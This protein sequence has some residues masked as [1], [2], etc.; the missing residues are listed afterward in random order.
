MESLGIEMQYTDLS[1]S[2]PAEDESE[3]EISRLKVELAEMKQ[4]KSEFHDLLQQLR[5]IDHKMAL[6]EEDD[7][8]KQRENDQEKMILNQKCEEI[9]TLNSMLE[10]ELADIRAKF[11]KQSE[12]LHGEQ[13][14]KLKL[15]SEVTN[16]KAQLKIQQQGNTDLQ[17]S[18]SQEIRQIREQC[19]VE[20]KQLK[21]EIKTLNSKCENNALEMTQLQKLNEQLRQQLTEVVASESGKVAMQDYEELYKK[22]SNFEV[23]LQ[24]ITRDNASERKILKQKTQKRDEIIRQLEVRLNSQVSALERGNLAIEKLTNELCES[25]KSRSSLLKQINT[26]IE[27][28]SHEI[29]KKK[30]WMS[31]KRKVASEKAQLLASLQTSLDD[32]TN[33]SSPNTTHSINTFTSSYTPKSVSSFHSVHTRGSKSPSRFGRSS[34]NISTSSPRHIIDGIANDTWLG[35]SALKSSNLSSP[36]PPRLQKYL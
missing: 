19:D 32:A 21:S 36:L 5:G 26:M 20:K 3:T 8:L 33:L 35:S 9:Q 10:N 30:L 14:A 6:K 7:D 24:Q 17:D 13:H 12:L 4:Y 18:L 28:R 27:E 23:Q 31:A 1:S 29:E 2:V 25:Q 15:E 11:E 34:L 22:C 16:F